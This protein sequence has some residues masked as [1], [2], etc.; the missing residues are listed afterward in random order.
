MQVNVQEEIAHLSLGDKRRDKRFIK[1]IEKKVSVPSASIPEMGEK[2]SDIKMTYE[3]YNNDNVSESGIASCIEQATVGRC[4]EQE[5]VLNIMDTTSINFSSGAEGL[6]YLDHGAGEGLMV[7]NSLALDAQGT[8]LGLLSQKIWAREKSTM[9][10]AKLRRGKDISEKESYRWIESMQHAEAL[11]KEVGSIV[12]IA[13]RE[14][15]IYELFTTPRSKN[16]ELLIR[17]THDRK[18]LLGNSMWKEVEAQ[19]VL[20]SFELDIPKVTT[21]GIGKVQMEVRVSMI[22]LSPPVNKPEQHS[23]IVYGILVKEL[24]KKEKGL[25]W[26]LISTKPV[27]TASEALQLVQWYGYRWRIERLHYVLKSGCRVEELQMRNVK[28]LRKAILVYSLC[29]F[30]IMQMLYSSRTEPDTPCTKYF[31]ELEWKVLRSISSKSPV[32]NPRA[33]SLQEMVKEIAK[34]GGYIGRNGDGPPGI[35]NLWKGL[36]YFNMAIRL[37]NNKNQWLSTN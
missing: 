1:I 31:S 8:P 36:Q 21:E 10:K 33:P 37:V 35:K 18:T 28:A 27:N 25:E 14:S 19:P 13:D 30:K 2:W 16:S 5:V 34:L 23:M 6:G 12:H 15:D 7:H 4:N 9:G 29:A 11:L 20:S 22:M 24:G 17:A 32:T 26:R 3:F